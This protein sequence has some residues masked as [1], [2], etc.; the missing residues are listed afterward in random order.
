VTGYTD[1][2]PDGSYLREQDACDRCH[3][4][5]VITV[6]GYSINPFSGVL[7]PDPQEAHDGPCPDCG[8]TGWSG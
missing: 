8:G 5:G 1:R 4:D 3:G 2:G 7:V 6:G